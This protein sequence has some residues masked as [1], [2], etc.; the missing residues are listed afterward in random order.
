MKSIEQLRSE[1]AEFL[2]DARRIVDKAKIERRDLNSAEVRASNE[3]LDS[4]EKRELEIATL[5]RSNPHLKPKMEQRQAV[6]ATEARGLTW[7]AVAKGQL[8]AESTYRP[9]ERR[10]FWADM[11]GAGRGDTESR[12]R[13]GRSEREAMD[14]L[15]VGFEQRDMANAST[16]GGEFVPPLYLADQY[17]EPSI[18]HRPF[19]EALPKAPLPATGT[20]ISIPHLASGVAVAARSDLGAVQETDGVTASIT[21]SV[22]EIAGMIDIGRIA[23]MR[24]EPGLDLV[25]FR[26]LNR[27]YDSYLDTQL[28]AGSGTDPQHRGI[29]N[30]SGNNDVAYTDASPTAAEL[31]P[32]VFRAI[33]EIAEARQGEV[34]ADTIVMHS[35]RAAWLASQL[36]STFPLF[37]V[38]SLNQ[39]GGSQASGFLDSFSGLRV[40]I[41]NNIG[42]AYGAGTN[43][44][45]IYVVASEDLVLMEGPL[46]ARVDDSSGSGNGI[47]RLQ[48]F[49]FSAFLSKRYPAAISVIAGTGLVDPF[50]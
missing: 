12:E 36:S 35:R 47:V 30:V 3:A 9:D 49:A 37:Q 4:A 16:T 5:E 1:R 32:F 13:L 50:V 10:S 38:Q 41:D 48:V 14:Y 43:E 39:A 29:R 24:S 6:P 33:S 40:A 28:L 8:R 45:E 15:G 46:M 11:V 19:A 20:A 42:T 31:Y 25:L 17:V 18:A 44:D 21:H 23:L 27:R 2:H 34:F 22:N 26:T 7:G